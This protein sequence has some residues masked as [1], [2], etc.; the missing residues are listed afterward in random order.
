MFENL[1]T[2]KKKNKSQMTT[3][4][5]TTPRQAVSTY[6]QHY[7]TNCQALIHTLIH[8]ISIVQTHQLFGETETNKT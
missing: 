3:A 2:A 8:T 7:A 1:E 5:S 4:A 6:K